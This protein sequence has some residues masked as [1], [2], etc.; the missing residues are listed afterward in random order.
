MPEV[1]LRQLALRGAQQTLQEIYRLF[2]ELRPSVGE[3]A[4]ASVPAAKPRRALTPE[5]RRRLSTAMRKRW[6][7]AKANGSAA[8]Q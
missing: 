7:V 3:P 5:G 4:S 2:P 6:K 8:S 1:D